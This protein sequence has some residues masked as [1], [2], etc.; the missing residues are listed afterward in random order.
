MLLLPLGLNT[1]RLFS[2]EDVHDLMKYAFWLVYL[3]PLLL[4]GESTLQG[5]GEKSA[6]GIAASLLVLLLLWGNVQTANAVYVKKDLEQEATLSL[7]TRVLGRIEAEPDYV[8]GETPL[9]FVGADQ[10]LYPQVYGF[11]AYYDITGAE[12]PGAI[13]YSECFYYYNA[14]TAYFRYVLNTRAQ[15]AD[16]A[17]WRALQNDERV[18]AMPAYP[19]RDCLQTLDGVLVVKLGEPV[20]W[21]AKAR[22]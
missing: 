16:T 20:D 13:P 4:I 14:Y 5:P 12:Y 1:A 17:T 18:E 3:L 9:V 22:E 11:E 15:M 7:M 2:G 6:A 21:S 10:T 8:P 19:A